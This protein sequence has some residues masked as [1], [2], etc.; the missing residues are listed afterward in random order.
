MDNKK[1]ETSKANITFVSYIDNSEKTEIKNGKYFSN[2]WGKLTNELDSRNIKINIIHLSA[3]DK[4]LKN[5]EKI[6]DY[7]NLF[8]KN[9]NQFH[10]VINSFI[11]IRVLITSL[12]DWILIL[13]KNYIYKIQVKKNPVFGFSDIKTLP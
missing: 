10:A 9:D 2:Y 5:R 8:N 1:W 13:I 3:Y 4:L 11:C 12:K 6:I 7:I